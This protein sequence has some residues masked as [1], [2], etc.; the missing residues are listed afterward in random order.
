MKFKFQILADYDKPTIRH[1]IL[2]EFVWLLN[3]EGC[4]SVWRNFARTLRYWTVSCENPI[5]FWRKLKTECFFFEYFYCFTTCKT[6]RKYLVLNLYM[7]S[8][9]FYF[10][11]DFSQKWVF[12][13]LSVWNTPSISDEKITRCLSYLLPT[14]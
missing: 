4:Y 5:K 9:F 11:Q 2:A 3:L 13:M 8:N 12:Q 14:V 7:L 1:V 10:Y 6:Q